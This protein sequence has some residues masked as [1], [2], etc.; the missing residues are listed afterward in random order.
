MEEIDHFIY[1][2]AKM[3]EA[4]AV[5]W[6]LTSPDSELVMY[7]FKFFP[8]EPQDVRLK[9]LHTSLCASDHFH[10]RGFWGKHFLIQVKFLTQPV[11]AT[12]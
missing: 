2:K 11:L 8:L 9:I 12:R 3:E 7:P 4:D 5:A 10:G 6:V 1:P